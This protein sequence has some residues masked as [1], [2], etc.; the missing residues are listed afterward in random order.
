MSKYKAVICDLDG[1]ILDHGKLS[2]FTKETFKKIVALGVKIYIATGRHHLDAKYFKEKLGIKSFLISSNG[3]K[4]HNDEL[5]EIYSVTL[6]S[7]VASELVNLS[8]DEEVEP[9]V[10]TETH[11][12]G[13]KGNY[14][15][16]D[17]PYKVSSFTQNV[18][19][20]L[21]SLKFDDVIKFFYI[22]PNE[23]KLETISANIKKK[24]GENVSVVFSAIQCLEVMS[25]KVSKGEAIKHMLE[26]EGL[27]SDE[28]IAFGDGMNDLEMLESVGKGFVMG[29][30][31]PKLK[32]A[33]PNHDVI[34]SVDEDA[35]ALKLIEIFLTQN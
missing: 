3:S 16:Q 10:F 35:V 6:P 5:E 32:A 26:M 11:W 8:V 31:N 1:T 28:V 33:L 14:F 29:N 24:Y 22:S 27:Q 21:Q 9:N 34:G 13:T 25:A 7:D 17:D 23:S 30:A 12:F 4:I 15:S 18:V 20:S 19:S 2:E